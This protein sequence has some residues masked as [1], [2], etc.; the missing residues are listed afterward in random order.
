VVTEVQK[1]ST[2][3]YRVAQNDHGPAFLQFLD[4]TVQD[5]IAISPS[6]RVHFRSVEEELILQAATAKRLAEK[7]ETVEME[8]EA[9]SIHNSLLSTE[10]KAARAERD[11][12][13]K[14]SKAEK[15]GSGFMM[16]RLKD[17]LAVVK[18]AVKEEIR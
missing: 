9:L 8:K 15:Y 16:W 14:L 5:W 17:D 1:L 13:A 11:F 4:P 10:L 6:P 18:S 7:I 3:N 2:G 12:L